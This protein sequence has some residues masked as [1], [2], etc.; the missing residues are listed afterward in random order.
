MIR[1]TVVLAVSALIAQPVLAAEMPAQPKVKLDRSHPDFMRCV[2][3]DETGSLVKKHKVCRTN[4]EWA[5][6]RE[7]ESSDARDFVERNRSGTNNR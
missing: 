3:V 4:A 6:L 2:R 7:R 1:M 5:R